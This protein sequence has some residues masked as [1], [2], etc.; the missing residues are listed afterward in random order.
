MSQPSHRTAQSTAESH[1][2]RS[3][4]MSWNLA[5][6]GL[7]CIDRVE[8]NEQ[9]VKRWRYGAIEIRDGELDHVAAR[10]WPRLASE[11]ES[12]R[13]QLIKTLPVGVCRMY[14]SFPWRTPGFMVLAYAHSGPET[15]YQT[16]RCG[17]R[18]L[19]QIA[20]VWHAQAIVCQ[21]TNN[22]LSERTMNR[23]GYEKHALSLGDNHYIRRLRTAA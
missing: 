22:R 19:E 13:E 12:L 11:W 17:L 20:G 2:W 8:G 7:L 21:A 3:P 15:T 23:W 5:Q 10:W 14:Y 4:C 1:V 18:T 16:I 9:I 6:M